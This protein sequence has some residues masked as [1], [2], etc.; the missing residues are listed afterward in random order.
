[1]NL[2]LI[3]IIVIVFILLGIFLARA[4]NS[5][6]EFKS[7]FGG[8]NKYEDFILQQMLNDHKHY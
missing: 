5:D 2:G 4:D 7:N 6:K 1:M 3:V 8:K